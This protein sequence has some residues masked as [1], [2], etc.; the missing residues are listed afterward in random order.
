[1]L[2][3]PGSPRR[4]LAPPPPS[5]IDLEEIPMNHRFPVVVIFVTAA[6]WAAFAIWL[7]VAPGALLTGFEIESSTPAMLTEIRAFYGGVELAIAA[8]MLVLWR[9]GQW[10]A[11]LLVG[12]LPLFG[13][14]SGRCIGM[15]V[16]GFA[17]MH[18]G[19]AALEVIGAGFCLA[20]YLSSPDQDSAAAEA[21]SET[22]DGI[23]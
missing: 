10:S 23:D 20:A 14:A 7:G 2:S 12:G 9:R 16:D 22:G 1:M 5:I 15:V 18:A 13:A 8:A 11:A 6:S 19:F 4:T 21:A 17:P 3:T